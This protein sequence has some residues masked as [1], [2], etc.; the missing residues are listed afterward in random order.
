MPRALVLAICRRLIEQGHRIGAGTIL[1]MFESYM[2]PNEVRSMRA[3]Q[4]IPP[5]ALVRGTAVPTR[6]EL[7]TSVRSVSLWAVIVKPVEPVD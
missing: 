2:R 7:D 4:V 1:L 5:A 3:L 6:S